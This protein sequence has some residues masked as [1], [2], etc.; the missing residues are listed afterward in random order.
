MNGFLINSPIKEN[1]EGDEP[2]RIEVQRKRWTRARL[3]P[4]VSSPSGHFRLATEGIF[5]KISMNRRL[6]EQETR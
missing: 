3:E 4:Q 1:P 5:Y 2:T 6:D